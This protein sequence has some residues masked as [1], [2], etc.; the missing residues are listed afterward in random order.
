MQIDVDSS[1]LSW[2]DYSADERRLRLGLRDGQVYD[3]LQVPSA[4][5]NKLLTASSKGRY[6]NEH[7]RNHFQYQRLHQI[8][9][10]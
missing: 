10:T 3:F 6:F 1:L 8:A 9:A 7:I 2:L 4:I 5:Y